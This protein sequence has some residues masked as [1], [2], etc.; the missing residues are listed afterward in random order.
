MDPTF[1]PGPWAIMDQVYRPG[2][3]K[4]G[5]CNKAYKLPYVKL[6]SDAYTAQHVRETSNLI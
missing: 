1:R 5:G 4:G 3:K 6:C 2:R